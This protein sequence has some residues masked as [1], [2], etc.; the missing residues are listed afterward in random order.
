MNPQYAE[1]YW[2]V[3]GIA[4]LALE[5]VVPGFILFF[6]GLG[7]LVVSVALWFVPEGSLSII[8]QIGIFLG[9]SLVS[10]AL[11]RKFLLNKIFTSS[12]TSK[13]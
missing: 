10:F 6:F 5:M 1:I 8:G 9:F 7:A 4:L 12:G 11:L 3:I 13:K 2:L